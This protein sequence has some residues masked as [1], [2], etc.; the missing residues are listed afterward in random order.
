[1]NDSAINSYFVTVFDIQHVGDLRVAHV[2]CS[3]SVGLFFFFS[4]LILKIST[5]YWRSTVLMI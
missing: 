2:V 1:M 5:E 4:N 3:V